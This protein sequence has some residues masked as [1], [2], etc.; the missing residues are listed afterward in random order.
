MSRVLDSLVRIT[1]VFPFDSRILMP[2][3]PDLKAA[4]TDHPALRNRD[5]ILSLNNRKP[6]TTIISEGD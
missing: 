1:V 4:D 5:P 2:R 6:S 3:L